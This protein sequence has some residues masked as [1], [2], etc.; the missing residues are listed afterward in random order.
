MIYTQLSI[1]YKLKK[2]TPSLGVE[3][4]ARFYPTVLA[5]QEGVCECETSLVQTVSPRLK[6]K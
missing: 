5:E 6:K 2:K 1:L 4:A 3:L